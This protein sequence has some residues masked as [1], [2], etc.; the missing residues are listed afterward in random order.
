MNPK[1]IFVGLSTI[2]IIYTVSDH[3]LPN[4]KI[5]AHSQQISV[6]GPAT[7]AAATFACLGGSTTLVTSVGRHP[8]AAMIHEDLRKSAIDLIDLSPESSEPPPISSVWVD[9]KGQRSVVSANAAGRKISAAIA[10]PQQVIGADVVM[11]DGHVM[12]ACKAWAEAARA[13]RV[14]VVFDGGSWKPETDIL[15]KSVD[16]AICSADFQPPGCVRESDVVNYLRGAGVR[17]IGITH[18]PD[19][20]QYVSSSASGTIEVPRVEAVDTTG[21]GDVFHG[22][23]CFYYATGCSFEEALGKAA[24][25]A[26]E[27]CRHPGTRQ[28]MQVSGCSRQAPSD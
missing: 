27:A 26:A 8:L 14:P 18:G 24:V 7:N 28:W 17:E 2:D 19:P 16:I 5:A 6:G 10:D 4:Q 13:A 23:F 9:A 22:A 20:I 3:P 21:A 15:L 1:G 11:V 12:Q 25:I